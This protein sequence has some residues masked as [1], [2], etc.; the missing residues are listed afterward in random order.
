MSIQVIDNFLH[1]EDF[2]AIQSF[3]YNQDF[4]WHYYDYKVFQEESDKNKYYE[5]QM[6]HVFY[7]QMY[8][9]VNF[10]IVDPLVRMLNVA[11]LIKIK[12][13][14]TF[15][16]KSIEKFSHHTDN[17]Y[18]N[19]KTAIFYLNTND[20]YTEFFD[21]GEKIESLENRMVIFPSSLLHCGTT[22]TNSKTRMLINFNYF[23]GKQ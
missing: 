14:L 1:D 7:G 5:S 2:R 17:N 15:P 20:G 10:H 21:T 18:I 23:D 4:P 19:A 13:N 8:P 16:W 3:L 22:H 11:S 9:T 6:V 12:A